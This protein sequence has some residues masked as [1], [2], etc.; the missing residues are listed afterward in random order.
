M[1]NI[2]KFSNNSIAL[3]CTVLQADLHLKGFTVT[4]F[5][6]P[7]DIRINLQVD[8][9]ISKHISP[10]AF[11]AKCMVWYCSLSDLQLNAHYW[12]LQ[13]SW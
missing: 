5:C 4:L 7:T 6:I 3:Q 12:I 11:S 8:F 13:S 9:L 1:S 2:R 10:M